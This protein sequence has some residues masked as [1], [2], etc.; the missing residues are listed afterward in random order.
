[1]KK[2][3]MG[4]VVVVVL[5][6]G[7]LAAG[8]YSLVDVDSSS[9]TTNAPAVA[10]MTPEELAAEN[11]VL[12][13]Q[14][15]DASM[16]LQMIAVVGSKSANTWVEKYCKDRRDA[17]LPEDPAA[18]NV[19]LKARVREA[20]TV[21]EELQAEQRKEMHWLTQYYA[22]ENEQTLEKL[23]I[24]SHE[25][26]F[27]KFSTS[28]ELNKILGPIKNVK[29]ALN[30]LMGMGYLDD[31]R[32]EIESNRDFDLGTVLDTPEHM[33]KILRP[34]IEKL[35]E[36]GIPKT[37]VDFF[38][39]RW[40]FHGNSKKCWIGYSLEGVPEDVRKEMAQNVDVE[41]DGYRSIAPEERYDGGDILYLSVR[42][43]G[44]TFTPGFK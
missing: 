44:E 39:G 14:A 2:L 25:K 43:K 3:Q 37:A 42:A 21:F 12:T 30:G 7:I 18:A 40:S 36:L 13:K 10:S 29:L 16:E 20:R 33:E 31:H 6:L 17:P 22:E 11:E 4:N 34:Y 15:H 23:G 9:P 41:R 24:Q 8:V 28:E 1:M 38:S 19:E 26:T 32:K 5:V 27:G 35:Y